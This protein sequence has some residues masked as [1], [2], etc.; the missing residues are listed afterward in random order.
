MKNLEI[1]CVTNKTL[2]YLD[3]SN[4]NIGWVGNEIPAKNYILCNS[5]DNIFYKE[6]YYS[7]LTFQY[8]YWKNKLRVEENNWIGFCQKRRFWIKKKSKNVII[9]NDNFINHI[10]SD[11]PEDWNGFDSIICEPIFVNRVKKIKMLKRGI[12][13]LLKNPSI[14]FN[15][16]KQSLAFHFDMHHGFGNLKKA[17]N[18][19]DVEDRLDFLNFVNTST[20]Y[21]PHIMFIA[22]PEIANRW[23]SVLF[24]W[25]LRCEKEFGFKELKGYDTQRLYAYLAERYLSFWFNK[26]TKTLTW[27]WTIFD[28]SKN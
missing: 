20:S 25:L 12:I 26:H 5:E 7:E 6:K 21:N 10:L 28:I 8:W 22:K 15:E 1:Y 24:P 27:P 13:P 18:L 11:A 23:F 2:N 19:I 9:D 17:I 3:Q 4:Y 14:F 16:N